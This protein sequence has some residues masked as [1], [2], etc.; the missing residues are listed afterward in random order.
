MIHTARLV[1]RLA[2]TIAVFNAQ[3]VAES[4][5]SDLVNALP[6]YADALRASGW[7]PATF[8]DVQNISIAGAAFFEPR[9]QMTAYGYTSSSATEAGTIVDSAVISGNVI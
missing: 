3:A 8:S 2:L 9:C 1:E 5:L 7:A 6:Q 4:M